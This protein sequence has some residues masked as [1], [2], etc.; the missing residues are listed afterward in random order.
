MGGGGAR[1]HE[2]CNIPWN[3]SRSQQKTAKETNFLIDWLKKVIISKMK[4]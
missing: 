3:P 1:G 4:T 2:P